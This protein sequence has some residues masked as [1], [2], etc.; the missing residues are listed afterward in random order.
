M[1]R[2]WKRRPGNQELQQKKIMNTKNKLNLGH[3][4]A[5]LTL[6]GLALVGCAT[7]STRLMHYDLSG[8]QTQCVPFTAQTGGSGTGC[9]G[10]FTGYAKMTNGASFWFTPP[11][12]TTSGTLTDASGFPAPYVSVA[13][14]KR[15]SDLMTWCDT[16]SV[17]F[18]ATN[19]TT[20]SL[21]FYVKSPLPPPTNTQPMNLQITWQ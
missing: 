4:I 15:K 19:N 14:V 12:N 13:C 20:Y 9:P 21:T 8:P 6:V 16:N 18:P 11:T 17:T 2:A 3:I 7:H 5:A 10:V 1:S